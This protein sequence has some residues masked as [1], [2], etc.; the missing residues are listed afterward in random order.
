MYFNNN[1][2][3]M[4]LNNLNSK[5]HL[6][7]PVLSTSE[8][9]IAKDFISLNR[10]QF[11][12]A[13][14]T[15]IDKYEEVMNALNTKW[16]TKENG[17]IYGYF[18]ALKAI[19]SMRINW[20]KSLDELDKIKVTV[21]KQDISDSVKNQNT[22][23]TELKEQ[24]ELQKSKE[25]IQAEIM[26]YFIQHPEDNITLWMNVS[27]DPNDACEVIDFWDAKFEDE[28]LNKPF[29]WGVVKLTWLR[30]KADGTGEKWEVFTKELVIDRKTDQRWML[31]IWKGWMKVEE[32]DFDD[33]TT[34]DVPYETYF[35]YKNG[36]T[37][38]IR[39][40]KNESK[41]AYLKSS[42]WSFEEIES[43]IEWLRGLT[44]EVAKQLQ[45]Q[46]ATTLKEA[47]SYWRLDMTINMLL[48]Q[49]P[50]SEEMKTTLRG[51]L[52]KIA[53]N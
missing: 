14:D 39:L 47:K 27:R 10:N 30:L 15:P 24:E 44:P 52:Y 32:V 13:F 46:L 20:A 40:I 31:F 3:F 36:W 33:I 50:V 41:K 35:A 42:D 18:L 22:K 23:I 1:F 17:F 51:E 12:D 8:V 19:I 6:P 5:E 49:M 9:E 38:F 53:Q 11:E 37:T 21:L 2:N 26:S 16:L 45:E 28:N 7:F 29:E 34:C 48:S 4:W 43:W 25:Q